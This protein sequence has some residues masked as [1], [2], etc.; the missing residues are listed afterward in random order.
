MV[1]LESL[2]HKGKSW[3]VREGNGSRKG[4][5]M[6]TGQEILELLQQIQRDV[7]D[8]EGYSSGALLD[9]YTDS[10][11]IA[12]ILSA[13]TTLGSLK[14][15][16]SMNINVLSATEIGLVSD[17]DYRLLQARARLSV[18]P[19]GPLSRLFEE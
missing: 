15:R 8:I 5:T 14:A 7:E 1:S 2:V 19:S 10:E 12:K 18:S 4:E 6:S 16:H 9:A 3:I 17:L 13:A 11:A